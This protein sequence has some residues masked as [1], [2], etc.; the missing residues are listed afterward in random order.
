MK[1][2][3]FSVFALLLSVTAFANNYTIET[4]D[5]ATVATE[6]V[7]PAAD[8][9]VDEVPPSCT[10]TVNVTTTDAN[11]VSTTVQGTITV[12]GVNCTTA[13]KAYASA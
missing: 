10:F 13:I 4:T 6:M 3:F 5:M 7:A 12:H 2:L 8:V 9:I 1:S 11:G